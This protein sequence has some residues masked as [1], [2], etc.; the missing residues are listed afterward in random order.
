MQHGGT[1][2]RG[3]H[4]T[5]HRP[6]FQGWE[7]VGI[8]AVAVVRLWLTAVRTLRAI[9]WASIDDA[10]FLQRARSIMAGQWMGPYNHLT[11]IKGAGYPLWIAAVSSLHIPLLFAQQLLYTLAC[12]ATCRALAPVIRSATARVALFAVLALNPMTYTNDVADRVTREGVY[13]ALCLLACAGVAGIILRLSAR[14]RDVLPWLI[15]CGV[16]FALLWHTREEGI[17]ITPLPAFAAAGILGWL[18]GD[19][20]A[21]WR[22]AVVLLVAPALL[23]IAAH[24]AIVVANG[25]RYGVSS[26]VEFKWRPFLLAYGSLSSV[27]QH[28][29]V[30]HV[31][32][33]K[34][35]RARVYAV[36]PA[37][38]EL[39]PQIEGD[40]GTRWRGDNADLANGAFMWAFREAVAKSGYYARGSA[41]VAD[42]YDRISREINSA[43]LAGRLDAREARATL[44]PPLAPGQR[45]DV[46]S[47]WFL[48]ARRLVTFDS[49]AA[50]PAYSEG[51][52][53]ELREF[54]ET[55]RTPLTPSPRSM[56]QV[57]LFAWIIHAEGS[58]DI[59]V[60]HSDGTPVP[61][62]QIRRFATPDLYDH[63]K[64]SWKDFPPARNAGFEI[65]AHGPDAV[66]VLSLRG[67]PVDRITL[68]TDSPQH[69]H[70]LVRM[71]VYRYE[72]RV[73]EPELSPIDAFRLAALNAIARFYQATFPLLLAAALLLFM[74][75]WRK[76]RDWTVAILLGGIFAAVAAR[77]LILSI[78]DVTSFPVFFVAYESPAYPLLLTGTFLAAYQGVA[79]LRTWRAATATLD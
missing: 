16:A 2:S 65:T 17:W 18:V 78:I 77:V 70:P 56:A 19:W 23:L 48:G 43:R 15:L 72:Y 76:R 9:G 31:P 26:D 74:L 21:R 30:P 54:A 79:A 5:M 38:A 67:Q 40:L 45:R 60:E 68:S 12:L 49:F 59:T 47:R 61:D 58:L 39:R 4:G 46:I 51:P 8:A 63:L 13:P 11:L 24:A 44:L 29:P 7:W 71:G 35:V 69:H 73:R 25:L 36:S 52:A 57:H 1:P 14:R 62:A 32:V 50:K 41:A 42:Y 28:P 3:Y 34:E 37:F 22:R 53:R 20:E 55:T 66:L 27:R 10:W 6:R 75:T 33:P 64:I